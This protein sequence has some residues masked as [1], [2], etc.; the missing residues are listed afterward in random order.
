M[1]LFH[2]SD[3]IL[4]L[5]R[6]ARTGESLIADSIS[7]TITVLAAM[8]QTNISLWDMQPRS[9][10]LPLTI[11]ID[12]FL[13]RNGI[14]EN[15]SDSTIVDGETVTLQQYDPTDGLWKNTINM[16]TSY[17]SARLYH[18]H[19]YGTVQFASNAGPGQYQFRAH[20]SGNA[21]KGLGGCEK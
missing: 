5:Q 17:D 4:L 15:R 14:E 19:F 7:I 20:F 3:M 11:T 6:K 16:T 12:G 13:F 1:R 10:S 8:T 18:G 2:L 21:I 9:G